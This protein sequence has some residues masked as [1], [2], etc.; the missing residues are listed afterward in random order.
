MA[1]LNDESR[2]ITFKLVYTG[3][4]MAGKTSNL[5]WIHQRLDNSARSDLI[6]LAT[7][8]DRTLFFDFLAVESVLI[9]GYRSRFQLYTV[10]GQANYN[11]TRQ[12]VLRGADGLV[13]V[14]DS[15]PRRAA[16]NLAAWHALHQHL[17]ANRTH[18]GSLPIVL[19]YNKRDLPNALPRDVMD[20][21][22]RSSAQDLTVCEASATSG[23]G[24]F[25][26]LNSLAR[27]VVSRFHSL[28]SRVPAAL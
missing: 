1:I 2:E 10:P 17:A 7:M 9:N 6:T 15:D 25:N 4:P 18:P 24:V 14:A 8:S 22:F 27:L 13:F 3:T 21:S 20:Q 16:D 23:T 19:Q 26:T 28:H 11:A 12:I 5:A